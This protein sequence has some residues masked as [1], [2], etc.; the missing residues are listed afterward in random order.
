MFDTWVEL[1]NLPSVVGEIKG[2][3]EQDVTAPLENN[4]WSVIDFQP[5][6]PHSY[7]I[8]GHLWKWLKIT[9]NWETGVLCQHVSTLFRFV[10]D[11]FWIMLVWTVKYCYYMIYSNS[12]VTTI[13][14][15][16]YNLYT[17]YTVHMIVYQIIIYHIIVYE[18]RTCIFY[19]DMI[20]P[21]STRFRKP[22]RH[23]WG[24]KPCGSHWRTSSASSPT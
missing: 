18:Y 1:A 23:E 8:F 6:K 20:W 9:N 24:A 16:L 3:P 13:S 21:N 15:Y 4:L 17:C 12:A 22:S 14:S 10:L 11:I 2:W 7:I 19:T 5:A